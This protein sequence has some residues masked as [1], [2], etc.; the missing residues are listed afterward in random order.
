MIV[1]RKT[2]EDK[3]KSNK[4]REVI[5]PN[6][7]NKKVKVLGLEILNRKDINIKHFLE[8]VRVNDNMEARASSLWRSFENG[9]DWNEEIPI[10]LKNKGGRK[11]LISGFG[12]DVMF[13]H[14][15]DQDFYV[16]WVLECSDRKL[17]RKLR[18]WFN[19]NIF[20]KP[21]E[22][23]DLIEGAIQEVKENN[24]SNKRSV[25]KKWL[26]DIEP[27]WD[28]LTIEEMLNTITERLGTP[29]TSQNFHGFTNKTFSN[30]VDTS[31]SPSSNKYNFKLGTFDMKQKLYFDYML[32]GHEQHKIMDAV[33][34][35]MDEG[36]KTMFVC[37]VRVQDITG[38]KR[39]KNIRKNMIKDMKKVMAYQNKFFKK[40]DWTNEWR[41]VFEV[42]GFVPQSK[43]EN[44]GDL[45][46]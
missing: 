27:S 23:K 15:A 43:N 33:R 46:K 32:N 2:L 39:L 7:A 14:Y 30:W 16:Y 42:L 38:E 24:I 9:I 5:L 19:R 25:I 21:N 31:W 8:N 28:K 4:I 34:R 29:Q 1:D 22:M 3:I 18:L 11:D 17:E 37:G 44:N 12:R 41:K 36:V 6:W 40:T 35:Y 13:E 20:S 45:L 10:V 26:K